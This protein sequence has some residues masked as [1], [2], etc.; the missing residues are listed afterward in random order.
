MLL[1][2]LYGFFAKETYVFREPTTCSHLISLF[3]RL[4]C[5]S[6]IPTPNNIRPEMPSD[7]YTYISHTYI[8]YTLIYHIYICIGSDVYIRPEMLIYIMHTDPN[9]SRP[10][11]PIGYNKPVATL[12]SDVG[13][14]VFASSVLMYTSDP[15]C[16]NKQ[17]IYVMYLYKVYISL[18]FRWNTHRNPKWS[19]FMF[20]FE[21][22]VW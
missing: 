13:S 16:S 14:D 3:Y 7:W 18:S 8:W 11:H 21:L 9:T 1:S 15:K 22:A 4:H 19:K 12:G 6:Y 20:L 2:Y 10:S 5:S 17:C